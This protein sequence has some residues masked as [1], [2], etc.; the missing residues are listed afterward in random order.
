MYLCGG[1]F[2]LMQ[3]TITDEGSVRTEWVSEKQRIK[4]G[5]MAKY[6]H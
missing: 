3:A 4:V 1:F 5:D 6:F 2:G